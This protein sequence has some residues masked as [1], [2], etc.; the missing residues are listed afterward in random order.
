DAIEPRARPLRGDRISLDPGDLSARP[1]L[2]RRS[3]G[4]GSAP[5]VTEPAGGLRQTFDELRPTVLGRVVEDERA[6]LRIDPTGRARKKPRRVRPDLLA[7]V[8]RNPFRAERDRRRGGRIEI[9]GRD[10][11]PPFLELAQRVDRA[12]V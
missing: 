10:R 12:G 4:S 1:A 9:R 2:P 8:R 3:R 7:G 11:P 5:D 6:E